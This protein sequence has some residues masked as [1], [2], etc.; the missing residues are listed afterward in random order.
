[1]PAPSKST[2]RLNRGVRARRPAH[3]PAETGSGQGPTCT[4]SCFAR[5]RRARNDMRPETPARRGGLPC[6]SAD[7][8]PALS[9]RWHARP[10]SCLRHARPRL[11]RPAQPPGC[12]GRDSK[13]RGGTPRPLQQITHGTKA[14]EHKG[15]SHG[16]GELGGM[17]SP[18]ALTRRGAAGVWLDGQ[19]TGKIRVPTVCLDVANPALESNQG[20]RE[21]EDGR[22]VLTLGRRCSCGRLGVDG[23]V[24]KV[25]TVT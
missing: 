21:E 1:M 19:H 25:F 3:L 14:G 4:Q 17:T 23:G 20:G 10:Q 12:Q 13:R 6:G 9:A 11:A 15:S 16:D 5:R 24:A 2:S 18:R 8:R 22:G 7:R